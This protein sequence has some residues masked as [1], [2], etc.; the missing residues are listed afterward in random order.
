MRRF[1][2]HSGARAELALPGVTAAQLTSPDF[3]A[4]FSAAAAASLQVSASQVTVVGP[5]P[6]AAA[7]PPVPRR[8]V[9]QATAA[10][11][12]GLVPFTIS[13]LCVAGN[14]TQLAAVMVA[15]QDTSGLDDMTILLGLGGATQ[16]RT[17]RP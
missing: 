5:L 6:G 16:K 4:Q 8:T 13:G 9:L 17:A 15:L 11:A 2:I 1:F 7:P 3:A 14:G 10:A 12:S